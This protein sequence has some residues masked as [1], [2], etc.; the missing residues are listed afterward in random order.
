MS[1]AVVIGAA[2]TAV[3]TARRGTLSETPAEVLAEHVV[4]EVVQRSGLPGERFDDVYLGDTLYGGGDLGRYAA[5]AAGLE[6]VAGISVNRHCASSLTTTGLA[7]ASIMSGMESAIIAGGV[8]ASSMS[9]ISSFRKPHTEADYEQRMPPT[10]RH[11]DGIDDDVQLT[12]GWNLAQKFDISRERLDA[13]AFR[14]HQRAVAAID[15]GKFVDEITPITVVNKLGETVEFKVDEHPR[16][17]TTMEKLASLKPLHPEIEGFSITAGNAAGGNDAASAL[18]LA[19]EELAAA[20][21]L[22]VLAEI[23]AWGS[24]GVD[25][26]Y[27]GTGALVAAD[28]VLKRAGLGVKDIALWE[29]NEAFA[30]VPVVACQEMGID[31]ELVNFSGSGCSIGHPVAASGGR[32]LNTLIHELRRRGGGLGLATMCAGGGQGGA[33]LIRV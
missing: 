21:G 33:V 6:G 11:R 2:R 17:D 27:T 25:P 5:D 26:R 31:E 30:T 29:I 10:F 15:A 12:V 24:A 9:P 19:S 3:G 20:E 23:V 16:R 14:S 13:W 8:Q 32:M 18:A 28:K 7:A 4:R 22:D 1:K